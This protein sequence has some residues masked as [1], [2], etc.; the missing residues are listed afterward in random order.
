M[1]C[2]T[3]TVKEGRQIRH[4][5]YDAGINGGLG[6][7]SSFYHGAGPCGRGAPAGC[8]IIGERAAEEALR[9]AHS[10]TGPCQN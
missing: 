8:A 2:D 1:R 9:A 4:I 5:L 7:P 6:V 3:I 10:S